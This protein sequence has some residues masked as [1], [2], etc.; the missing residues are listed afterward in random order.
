MDIYDQN[1][2]NETHR[3]IRIQSVGWDGPTESE[4]NANPS[5]DEVVVQPS[6]FEQES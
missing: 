3:E 2:T 1:K 5:E 4:E 6:N